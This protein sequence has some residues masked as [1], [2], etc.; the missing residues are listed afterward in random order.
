MQTGKKTSKA[1][2]Q[3]HSNRTGTSSGQPVHISFY[4]HPTLDEDGKPD[5]VKIIELFNTGNY[6]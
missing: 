1:K 2:R 5:P 3:R 6:A 4:L